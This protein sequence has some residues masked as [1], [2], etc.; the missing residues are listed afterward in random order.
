MEMVNIT[1]MLVGSFAGGYIFSHSLGI[2]GDPW[3]AAMHTA[4][5]LLGL[6]VMA[7]GVFQLAEKTSAQTS[8]PFHFSLWFRHF[9]DVRE[10]WSNRPMWRATMGIC[11]FYG[12]GSYI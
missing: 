11:F 10:L 12:V 8:T 9:A 6:S 2:Q 1:A 7:C 3:R 4:W 5:I